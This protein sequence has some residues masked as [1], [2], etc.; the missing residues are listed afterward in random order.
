MNFP[1]RFLSPPYLC[2]LVSLFSALEFFISPIR[3]DRFHPGFLSRIFGGA[4]V[5]L[6]FFPP[7]AQA[8]YFVDYADSVGLVHKYKA[9]ML[10][11]GGLAVLDYDNDG[12]EDLFLP[13]GDT[14]DALWRNNG[15]GTWS[16]VTLVAGISIPEKMRTMGAI[17]GD[18]DNDGDKDLFVTTWTDSLLMVTTSPNF[19]LENNG[20]GTFSDITVQAGLTESTWTMPATF[21]DINLDG[22][23]DLYVGN[24]VQNANIIYDSLGTTVI[25]LD[26]T[27]YPN[28]L[29]LNNGNKTFTE[30]SQSWAAA[31]TG[32]ALAVAFTDANGDAKPDLYLSNDFGAFVHRSGMLANNHP[33][34][35]LTDVGGPGGIN[36][37]MFGMGIAV[38]DYDED[39]DFDYSETNM[40]AN[41]LYRNDGNYQFTELSGPAGVI[42][43]WVLQDSAVAVG[44]GCNFI[45]FDNNT[46]L[47][48][49]VSNG[50][51]STGPAVIP[52]S[53]P[54]NP[55]AFFVANGNGTFT[56]QSAAAGVNDNGIHR[57]SVQAD[58]NN[59]GVLDLAVMCISETDSFITGYTRRNI[60]LLYGMTQNSNH[61][62]KVKLQGVVSNRDGY[63]S[64]V[65]VFFGGRRFIREIDGGS[66]HGSI[67][68]SIAHFG[69]GNYTLAD[70]VV[71]VWP[72]GWRQ[73]LPTVGADTL[74]VVV[75]DIVLGRY[76]QGSVG[77]DFQLKVEVWPNP[78]DQI[79]Q[80]RVNVPENEITSRKLY[81]QQGRW[82]KDLSK[83]LLNI[84]ELRP[85]LYFIEISSGGRIAT[86][87]VA[88][89]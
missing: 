1:F 14:L 85:G 26:Y 23:L 7:I 34:P 78:A 75:E 6:F 12:W 76:D 9:G 33:S 39:G 55:N 89:Y 73:T 21:G 40:G 66:S 80:L 43:E 18:I 82:I 38:G 35:G 44:W 29:Y 47:D 36:S 16:N 72:G 37:M 28:F 4:V 48:L 30:V 59:D 46:Y 64:R 53:S 15:N 24:Y 60:Q 84:Q 54:M 32:C 3:Q 17:A 65:E 63:G 10:M 31:D 88:V 83:N 52:T 62:L 56:D 22:Y 57:G 13:G 70:S 20:D 8:Q 86:C 79:C 71:V 61:W 27:C 67:S 77:A 51:I 45:D 49:F 41:K 87:K 58:F 19:L 68:S 50:H 42:D 81:D 69:L 25:D 5:F 2:S 74:L 11:G